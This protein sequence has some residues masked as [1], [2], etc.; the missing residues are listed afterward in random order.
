MTDQT[1]RSA[2][3]DLALKTVECYNFGRYGLVEWTKCAEL[4]LSKG[5]SEVKAARILDS[6]I[7]RWAADD[8]GCPMALAIDLRDF[9]DAPA[10][11]KVVANLLATVAA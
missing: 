5:H 6:K 7:M 1:I 4:L 3:Q 10:N 8:A 2:A 9:L 11:R